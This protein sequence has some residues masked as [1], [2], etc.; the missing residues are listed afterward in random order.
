MRICAAF[1]AILMLTIGLPACG[2]YGPP[3]RSV[4]PKES[5]SRPQATRTEP[6]VLGEQIPGPADFD[7]AQTGEERG[8][9][10]VP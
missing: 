10:Q 3:V 8:E 4:V 7:D 6:Q 9:E 2:K 1:A 5:R